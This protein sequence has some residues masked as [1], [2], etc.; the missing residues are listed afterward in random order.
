MFINSNVITEGVSLIKSVFFSKREIKKKVKSG[1]RRSTRVQYLADLFEKK[2]LE[3]KRKQNAKEP[4]KSSKSVKKTYGATSKHV[5]HTKRGSEK[6][7]ERK[8]NINSLLSC[9]NVATVL[10]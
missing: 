2:K 10:I 7:L 5:S 4:N 8:G 3:E 1:K 9:T 6:K